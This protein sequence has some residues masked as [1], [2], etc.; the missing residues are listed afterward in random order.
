MLAELIN[1]Q[2]YPTPVINH[3][4]GNRFLNWSQLPVQSRARIFDC[5]VEITSVAFSRS[6]ATWHAT[7]VKVR[8][9][10]FDIFIYLSLGQIWFKFIF[11][12]SLDNFESKNPWNFVMSNKSVVKLCQN[13]YNLWSHF[14]INCS[15]FLRNFSGTLKFYYGFCSSGK[16]FAET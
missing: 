10:L 2:I 12:K 5:L 7:I 16:G 3:I 4:L 9:R 1:K 13:L 14:R 11:V 15:N 8:V 6:V